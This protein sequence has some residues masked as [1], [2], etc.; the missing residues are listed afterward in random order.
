MQ[1]E[2]AVCEFMEA[3]Q[4]SQPAVSYH[5]KILKNARLVKCSKEGKMIFYSLDKENLQKQI[6]RL[7]NQFIHLLQQNM[8]ET[9][10]GSIIRRN[11]EMCEKLKNEAS[12]NEEPQEPQELQELKEESKLQTI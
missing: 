10:P 11:P 1:R 6:N 3:L 12:R 7:E 2:T 5:L 8:P 4:L 9:I